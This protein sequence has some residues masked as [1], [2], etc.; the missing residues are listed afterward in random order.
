MSERIEFQ[1]LYQNGKPTFAVVP[2]DRFLELIEPGATIPHEVVGRVVRDGISLL[3]AW[4][5]HLDLTQEELARRAGMTQA[6]LSQM[7]VPGSKLR[8]A[9]REKLAEVLGLTPEQLRE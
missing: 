1:T 4:R 9:T 8:K 2:Y 5:E 7:E 6:A 3:R